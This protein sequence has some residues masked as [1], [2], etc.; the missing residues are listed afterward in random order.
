MFVQETEDCE[1]QQ[2]SLLGD[3]L[4][5]TVKK[6]DTALKKDSA[7]GQLHAKDARIGSLP[8]LRYSC[9]WW[10]PSEAFPFPA[11]FTMLNGKVPCQHASNAQSQ[12]NILKPA[13][14]FRQ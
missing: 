14:L 7:E 10:T 6:S 9:D 3:S 8:S 11:F 1:Q 12:I 4:L 13:I 2:N 5:Y